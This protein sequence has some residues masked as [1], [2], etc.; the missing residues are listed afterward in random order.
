MWRRG[1]RRWRRWGRTAGGSTTTTTTTTNGRDVRRRKAREDRQRGAVLRD[2]R[3]GDKRNSRPL[4]G[5]SAGRQTAIPHNK[6]R[7]TKIWSGGRVGGGF[8]CFFGIPFSLPSPWWVGRGPWRTA[9]REREDQSPKTVATKTIVSPCRRGDPIVGP[10]C[11]RDAVRDRRPPPRRP[12]RGG[13]IAGIPI[14][15]PDARRWRRWRRWHRW[16]LRRRRPSRRRPPG[17]RRLENERGGRRRVRVAERAAYDRRHRATDR[18]PACRDRAS[19]SVRR[20]SSACRGLAVSDVVLDLVSPPPDPHPLRRQFRRDFDDD[21]AA[22]RPRRGGGT[23]RAPSLGITITIT[24][25]ITMARSSSTRRGGRI[26]ECQDRRD[27]LAVCGH[28]LPLLGGG[29]RECVVAVV[30]VAADGRG[31]DEVR[32]TP[33]NRGTDVRERYGRARRTSWKV[34]SRTS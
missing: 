24:I 18:T 19:T 5:E 12:V 17:H 7:R 21:V 27:E 9:I 26:G 8:C 34:R 30:V 22:V 11:R 33:A 15:R 16:R 31:A 28:R 2:G 20:T 10:R 14:L 32:F 1:R 25:T 4:T 13:E 3:H 23:S 6:N 29:Y